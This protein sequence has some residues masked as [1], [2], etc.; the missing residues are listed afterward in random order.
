MSQRIGAEDAFVAYYDDTGAPIWIRQFGT[1]SVDLAAGVAAN[2]TI[3]TAIVGLT[4]GDLA[5][6]NAGGAD[7][8]VLRF[9]AFANQL[10]WA[11]QFG[12]SDDDTAMAVSFFQGGVVVA[13]NT[14]GDLGAP[15]AGG[16]DVF[17][18]AYDLG[19][20]PLWTRQLGSG[21]N[22]FASDVVADGAGGIVVI[23]YTSGA[24]A[25]G[26]GAQGGSDMFIAR[27]DL[28]G[29]PLWLRQFGTPEHDYG[30]RLHPSGPGTVSLLGTTQG[31]LWGVHAGDDGVVL[32]RFDAVNNALL[33]GTQFGSPDDEER[34]RP[35]CGRDGPGLHLRG[36]QRRTR[37]PERGELRRVCRPIR[38][39]LPGL[40]RQRLDERGGLRLL[41]DEVRLGGSVRRLQRRRPDDR[42]GPRVLPDHVRHRLPVTRRSNLRGACPM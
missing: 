15:N 7:A 21:A 14:S 42:R 8:Y 37:G 19:G 30:T 2:G 6:P 10:V 28:A 13:G 38:A 22:D 23:G 33:G 35:G 11:R 16:T 36:H 29:N 32:A 24:I 26:G 3:T 18:A 9:N 41:P 40:Q 25:G 12:A 34:D 39:V 1:P 5:G 27:C 20:N 31:S 17:L 4:E